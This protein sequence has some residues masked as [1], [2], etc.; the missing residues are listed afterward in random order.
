MNIS[1]DLT[2]EPAPFRK[3]HNKSARFKLVYMI[4]IGTLTGIC[5]SRVYVD[6]FVN[7]SKLG[8]F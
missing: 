1:V 4:S 5:V 2:S 8:S 6:A 3:A 7:E